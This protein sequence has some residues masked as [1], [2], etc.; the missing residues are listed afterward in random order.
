MTK[1]VSRALWACLC[2]WPAASLAGKVDQASLCAYLQ[3]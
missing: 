3:P 2:L 1:T